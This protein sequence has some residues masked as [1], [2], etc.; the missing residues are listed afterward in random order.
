[1]R[2]RLMPLSFMGV[3]TSPVNKAS[4]AAGKEKWAIAVSD[5]KLLK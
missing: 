4:L 2:C 1:M 3:D 5:F